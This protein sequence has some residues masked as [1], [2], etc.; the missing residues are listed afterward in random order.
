MQTVTDNNLR[1]NISS[2]EAMAVYESRLQHAWNN[3]DTSYE[4][5]ITPRQK[6]KIE[7]PGT[8]NTGAGPDFLNARLRIGG[9]PSVGAV[10]IHYRASDWFHHHHHLDRRYD[11]VILHLVEINDLAPETAATLPPVML[12]KDVKI[13]GCSEQIYR[14]GKCGMFFARLNDD[15]I[16][17]ILIAAGLHRFRQKADQ[18]TDEILRNG[19]DYA[20]T[21]MIFAALGYKQNQDN[22]LELFD[23]FIEHPPER[24]QKHTAALLWGES[25]LLPSP[26]PD[27]APEMTSELRDL[28]QQWGMMQISARTPIDWI[29]A[30]IRPYNSPERRIVALS[31]ALQRLGTAPIARV[32]ALYRQEKKP[33]KFIA[34]VLQELICSDP[35]W[36][37]RTGFFAAPIKSAAVLG[38]QQALEI[39]LNVILPIIYIYG[40]VTRGLEDL[41]DFAE[42]A[43]LNLPP[44]QNNRIV[45]QVGETWFSGRDCRKILQTAAARQGI[46]HLYHE[47]CHK[48]QSDCSSCLFYNSL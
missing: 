37:G 40:K 46:L 10:E 32:V 12:F 23:R 14:P 45:S 35:V 26:S 38:R 29:R 27:I 48:C 47:Y 30:G 28:W 2:A 6:I 19:A 25:G 4:Y 17:G 16:E 41:S 3:I 24:R 34:G 33:E 39:T 42:E 31:I 9:K 1:L 8:W 22:F 44:T 13:T 15:S 20:C 18:L 11:E 21:K 43:W 5:N 7:A 36:N